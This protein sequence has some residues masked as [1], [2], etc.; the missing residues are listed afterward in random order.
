MAMQVHVV[1]Q[2]RQ[3][4]L[5]LQNYATAKFFIFA[6]MLGKFQLCIIC[7]SIIFPGI[8]SSGRCSILHF[9]TSKIYTKQAFVKRT[10]S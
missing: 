3:H 2:D 10:S 6:L 8:V 9:I 1:I 7:D 4:R 5:F